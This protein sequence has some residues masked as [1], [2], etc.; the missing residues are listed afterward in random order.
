MRMSSGPSRRNEKPRSRFIEL[1]RGNAEVE[2]RAVD[3]LEAAASRRG[4]QV[5]ELGLDQGQAAVRLVH[6]VG[7]ERDGAPITIDADHAAVRGAED[8]A[9]VAAGAK[10][11]VEVDAAVAHREKLDG[12]PAE[13][14]NVTSQSASDSSFAAAARHHSRAPGGPSAVTRE[15]SC[16]LSARTFSVASASSA[17]KRPGSQI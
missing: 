13:H 2:H 16:F 1:H 4:L 7:A 5:G 8:G 12:E 9:R 14:G 15:P 17:R 11:R 6:E 3:L 10:C